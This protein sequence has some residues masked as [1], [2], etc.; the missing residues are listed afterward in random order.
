MTTEPRVLYVLKRFPQLSQ[1]FVIRE[2][3]ELQRMGATLGVDSLGPAATNLRH[4]ELDELHVPVRYVTR[5]PSWRSPGVLAT[6]ARLAVRRPHAWLP[7]A[8]RSRRGDRRRF[9]QAGLVAER[10]RRE[11]WTH[12]H[13]HFASAAA[14]VARDAAH[15]AGVTYTVTAHAKDIFHE[16]HAPHLET[17]LARAA[18]V[19]TVTRFN[20]AHLTSRLP[21]VPVVHVANGVPLGPDG[22]G[23]PDGPVLCVARMVDKK[24]IDVLLGAVALLAD[25][26]PELRVELVGDGELR[27][28][29]ESM[30]GLLG[31]ASRCTFRG[32][33]DSAGVAAAMDGCSM[34]VL[35]CRITPDG[36]RDGLP[37][38]LAEAMARAV[39]VI[40][41]ELVGIPELVR[42]GETGLLVPPDDTEALAVAIEKL[43]R[44][45][46][47]ARELGR[48]G[49]AAVAAELDPA[50]SA[51]ELGAVF[52]A[53]V[54]GAR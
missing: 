51:V 35:P 54:A 14:E 9:L 36:D 3:L 34:L 28:D 1:T 50:R 17:R 40:S 22:G 52:R 6:H 30:A 42:H 33:L 20:V 7:L 24:G 16:Q 8:L 27:A 10:I 53:A 37:T 12:V 45:R 5:R 39:P 19:V 41:T 11:G 21:A 4:P 32:S 2:L 31:I 48:A 29:L 23:S 15:L 49:R 18:A 38:V 25:E 26:L 13:A 44:D 47:A 43:W 46:D